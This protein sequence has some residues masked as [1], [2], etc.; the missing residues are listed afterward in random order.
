MWRCVLARWR[1]ST[2][3]YMAVLRSL[4]IEVKINTMPHANV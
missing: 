4:G 1:T 3:S 2:E